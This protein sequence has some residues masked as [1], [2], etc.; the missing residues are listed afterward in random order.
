MKRS[1][2]QKLHLYQ[3]RA[4]IV[5]ELSKGYAESEIAFIMNVEPSTAHR[6]VKVVNGIKT[7]ARKLPVL[8]ACGRK[9]PS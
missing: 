6:W 5:L 4:E 3:K 8:C 1:V 7:K 9:I 2:E